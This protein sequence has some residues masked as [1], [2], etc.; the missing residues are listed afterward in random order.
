MASLFPLTPY[1]ALGSLL[2]VA[3]SSVTAKSIIMITYLSSLVNVQLHRR[4][5]TVFADGTVQPTVT[6]VFNWGAIFILGKEKRPKRQRGLSQTQK[7]T[8][9]ISKSL[10]NVGFQS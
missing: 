2:S 9:V 7:V 5:C 6:R 1:T 8:I 4:G 10:D 3:L